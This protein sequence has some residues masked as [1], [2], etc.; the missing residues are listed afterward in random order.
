MTNYWL[1]GNIYENFNPDDDKIWETPQTK[2][3]SVGDQFVL[4]ISKGKN[5]YFLVG[6]YEYL[7][8]LKIRPI[9]YLKEENWIKRPAVDE[10]RE[11]LKESLRLNSNYNIEGTAW[12][13][14]IA[15]QGLKLTK[16]DFNRLCNLL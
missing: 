8:N 2:Q 3:F 1:R 10:W 7:G 6:I 5:Q 14:K 9:K 11:L 4:Y 15:S 16:N 12:I 13:G